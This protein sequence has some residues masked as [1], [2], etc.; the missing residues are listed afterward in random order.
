M[1]LKE[2]IEWTKTIND[3]DVSPEIA[4]ASSWGFREL[5]SVGV[6]KFDR[7][8]PLQGDEGYSSIRNDMI[9]YWARKQW[10]QL[11][12]VEAK[13]Q[14][15]RPGEICHPHLD[16]LGGYMERICETMPELLNSTHSLENP[17]VD[18]WRMFVAMDDHVQGQMFNINNRAWIWKAGDC[19]RL[20]N[21]Q[22]LHWTRN[23]SEKDRAIIKVT[24][25]KI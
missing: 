14:I 3:Y 6:P 2:Y 16:L 11:K 19:I 5:E 1:N 13:I 4:N 22:A 25:V 18:V 15:Q 17:A 23:T 12:F 10:P 7:A 20:D 24:G 9:S 21:W 8:N